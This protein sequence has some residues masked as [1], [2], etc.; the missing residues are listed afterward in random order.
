MAKK[1]QSRRVPR[2]AEGRMYGDGRPSQMSVPPTASAPARSDQPLTRQAGMTS[3]AASAPFDYSYVTRDLRRLGLT[4][5]A[6]F[7]LMFVLGLIIR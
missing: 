3:T 5:A 4:A 1:S 7:G 6:M 2:T